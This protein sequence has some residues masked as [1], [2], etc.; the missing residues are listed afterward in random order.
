MQTLIRTKL[1]RKHR[2]GRRGFS[3]IEVVVAI[4]IIAMVSGGVVVAVLKHKEKADANM[5]R[6]NAGAIRAGVKAWWIEHSVS[7]C[8]NVK[9]LVDDGAIDRG[10]AV[11]QDAWGQPWKI[12]CEDHDATVISRG[13]DKTPDTEDDIRVPHG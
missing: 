4:A 11:S 13:P 5:T 6:V 10:K 2:G 12:V 8:P 7:E 1:R 3:L 9:R